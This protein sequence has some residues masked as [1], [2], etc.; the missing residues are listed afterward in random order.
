MT[1]REIMCKKLSSYQFAVDDMQLYLDTHPYDA[2]TVD[3]MN[4]LKAKLESVR[5]EFEK[6]Y[7]PLTADA[8]SK[9]RWSWVKAPW[10]WETEDD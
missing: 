2:D 10:P 1:E 6:K 5:V 3:K 8:N 4:D 9:N 7:G